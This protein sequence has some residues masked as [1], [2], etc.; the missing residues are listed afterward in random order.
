MTFFK[1]KGFTLVELMIVIAIIGILSVALTATVGTIQVTARA[2]KCK[3]NLR[4][5][6]QAAYSYG[7][8]GGSY[9][10]AGSYEY[11]PP[12]LQGR[13]RVVYLGHKGWVSWT[14]G[15]SDSWPWPSESSRRSSFR[16][17]YFGEAAYISITN[18]VL[19][20]LV[21]KDA[22][23]YLCDTHRR[24]IKAVSNERVYRSYVMNGYFK[25]DDGHVKYRHDSYARRV[26]DVV[27]DGRAAVRLM[28]AELPSPPPSGSLNQD[29]RFSDSALEYGRRRGGDV[30]RDEIEEVIGFNHVIAKKWVA[31]VA[32]VDGHVEGLVLPNRALRRDGYPDYN[33]QD[34]KKLT[35]MLCEGQEIESE[36]RETMR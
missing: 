18:G 34:L 8:D 31:H 5:L 24:A 11:V 14:S 33:H 19:W 29:E 16:T 9:P 25:Y 36:I 21:G 22:N 10:T 7:V 17:R 28:F 6:A 3:A 26:E 23:I 30:Q 15:A 20:S 27:M 12:G 35:R 13:D 2:T 32:F 1:Q 4:A